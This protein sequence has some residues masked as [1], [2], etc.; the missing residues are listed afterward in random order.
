MSDNSPILSVL[1]ISHEQRELLRRCMTSILAQKIRVP[2]EIIISD[3]RSTD[4]TFELAQEYAEQYKKPSAPSGSPKGGEWYVPQVIAVHCDSNEC[5]PVHISERCGWNKLTVW[6]HAHGKYMVN[7]DADD[8]LKADDIYQAQLD[9]LESHPECSMCMQQ[10]LSLKDGD[11][12]KNGE[13]WPKHKLLTNGAI[14]T[15]QQTLQYDLRV[16]NPCYMM[17][18]HDEDDMAVLYGKHYDDTVIT[19]HN[20]QYGPAIYL[21]R[22]DYVWVQYP[23]SISH[24]LSSLDADIMYSLLPLHHAR[25]IPFLRNDFLHYGMHE[26]VHLMKVLAEHPHHELAKD[27]KDHLAQFDGF[28][29]RWVTNA[30]HSLCD[31][32][33]FGFSRLLMLLYQ[34][35]KPQ[36]NLGKKWIELIFDMLI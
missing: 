9:M 15:L 16:V 19:L 6:H 21:D 24:Q 23:K 31:R 7:I 3:D 10:V 13:A 26:L 27:N 34:K 22:A 4:G 33:R 20:F 14:I 25:F 1:C 17:R 29:Y 2:W 8:Y 12:Y 18:R 35:I 30:K 11:K 36:E 32:I 28:I 5:Q